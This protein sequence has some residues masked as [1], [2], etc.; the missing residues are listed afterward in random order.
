MAQIMEI[1]QI[2]LV[3]INKY[4][5]HSKYLHIATPSGVARTELFLRIS[6]KN[7]ENYA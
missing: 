7:L 1:A 4:N 6:R 3:T 5:I 2:I